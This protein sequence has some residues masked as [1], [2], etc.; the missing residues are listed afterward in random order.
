MSSNGFLSKFYYFGD[1]VFLLLY[2]NFLWVCF[3]LLGLIVFGI[4]PS[5]VSM[6][7]IFRKWTMG[8]DGIPT[9][10][11]FWR[12]YK[13]EFIRANG[14]GL[15]LIFIS[16]MLYINFNFLQLNNAWLQ[17]LMDILLIIAAIVYAIMVIYIFPLYV[18]YENNLFNYFKNAIFIAIYSPIRTIYLIAACLTLYYLYFHLPVFIFFIGASLSG[19]VI[20]YITYRTFVR[21]EIRQGQLQQTEV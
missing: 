14:L 4:G 17:Q 12:T 3:T 21:L 8:D 7:T 20:M 9:F 11:V 2:V 19:I 10:R 18:H 15:F 13:Q 6:F 1:T 16:Y 5:T